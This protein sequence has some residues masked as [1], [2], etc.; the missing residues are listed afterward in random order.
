MERPPEIGH[1]CT[2][3]PEPRSLHLSP[4]HW[5]PRGANADKG[6]DLTMTM[7]VGSTYMLSLSMTS[8]VTSGDF[9]GAL[10]HSDMYN[11]ASYQYIGATMHDG[12]G[13]TIAAPVTMITAVPEPVATMVLGMACSVMLMRRRK[14]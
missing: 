7:L 1:R 11:T 4:L 3:M 10:T 12:S 13:G 5:T 14:R 6:R 9:G 2:T 8:T